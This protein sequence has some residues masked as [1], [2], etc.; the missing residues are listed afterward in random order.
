MS[1]VK[2]LALRGAKVY[3][4]ARSKAKANETRTVLTAENSA[5][6]AGNLHWLP[7]DLADLKSVASAVEELKSKETRVDILSEL[8]LC[9]WRV[10]S[11]IMLIGHPSK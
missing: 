6:N 11:R 9:S 7:M 1:T 5:I 3:F 2:Y 10:E 4:T 8:S